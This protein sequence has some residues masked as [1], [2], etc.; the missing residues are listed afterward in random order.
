MSASLPTELLLSIFE[1]DQLSTRD[2]GRLSLVSR[3]VRRLVLPKLYH[4]IWLEIVIEGETH[5][6]EHH[7]VDEEDNEEV[8]ARLP[9]LSPDSHKL[10]SLLATRTDLAR[11]VHAVDFQSLEHNPYDV[12]AT[13]LV[14][15][16]LPS[17]PNLCDV[18]LSGLT[19]E[20]NLDHLGRY[21]SKAPIRRLEWKKRDDY[22]EEPDALWAGS[23]AGF[24]TSFPGL[25]DLQLEHLSSPL[26]DRSGRRLVYSTKPTFQLTTLRCPGGFPTV[27]LK[28]LLRCT[29]HSLTTLA[30][31]G[32][33]CTF[34]NVSSLTSLKHFEFALVTVD[35]PDWT[36]LLGSKMGPLPP[37]LETLYIEMSFMG[38]GPCFQAN[39]GFFS[40]LP[41][42][43]RRLTLK[44]VE[45]DVRTVENVLGST[46]KL[47]LLKFIEREI[48][49]RGDG[50]VLTGSEEE[51][52]AVA[53]EKGIEVVHTWPE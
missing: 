42:S 24:L 10:V 39:E 28:P 2:L 6:S 17:L 46:G 26:Q 44:E 45:L 29:Q 43:L 15:S 12:D 11:L 33:R 7:D 23:L 14:W 48:R 27:L 53:G 36:D 16:S 3:A 5:E 1:D 13:P 18:G 32:R 40:H 22:G 4:A 35:P 52:K 21:L 30:I 51:V 41:A 37:T 31:S 38:S 20:Q 50:N 9:K 34:I 47:P 8:D 19:I 49:W 25:A